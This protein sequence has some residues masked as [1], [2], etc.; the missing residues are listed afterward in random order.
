MKAKKHP[1]LSRRPAS[2]RP[3]YDVLPHE[4]GTHL[5][6]MIRRNLLAARREVSARPT[7]LNFAF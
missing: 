5:F 3:E 1:H 7:Q 2:R 6:A 4:L